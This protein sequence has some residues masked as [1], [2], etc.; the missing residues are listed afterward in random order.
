VRIERGT[1]YRASVDGKSEPTFGHPLDDCFAEDD[2]AIEGG[3]ANTAHTR[4]VESRGDRS[5]KPDRREKRRASFFVAY[6]VYAHDERPDNRCGGC[7]LNL[8]RGD[9][10]PGGSRSAAFEAHHHPWQEDGDWNVDPSF[11]GLRPGH[12]P[13]ERCEE[14]H[15]R[16]GEHDADRALESNEDG[17]QD[18][19]SAGDPRCE[20]FES[21]RRPNDGAYGEVADRD[22]DNKQEAKRHRQDSTSPFG[23][24]HGESCGKPIRRAGQESDARRLSDQD[25]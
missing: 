11:R 6:R 10:V 4:V 17:S 23:E 5:W 2:A 21:G 16:R 18:D 9:D 3:C 13:A 25:G 24:G 20:E 14:Q 8:R 1:R 15:R 12:E 22:G 19:Q 7:D